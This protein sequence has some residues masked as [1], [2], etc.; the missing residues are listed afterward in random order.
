MWLDLVDRSAHRVGRIGRAAS[1]NAL[2]RNFRAIQQIQPYDLIL[3]TSESL[4]LN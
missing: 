3:G 4:A 2:T 1:I